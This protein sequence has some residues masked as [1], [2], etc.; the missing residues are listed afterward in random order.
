MGGENDKCFPW[1][2]SCVATLTP[3]G[4]ESLGIRGRA[5][6]LNLPHMGYDRLKN[7]HYCLCFFLS[8]VR[9]SLSYVFSPELCPPAAIMTFASDT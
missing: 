7:P 2:G 8:L 5:H 6:F 9:I 3:G 4:L 1:L